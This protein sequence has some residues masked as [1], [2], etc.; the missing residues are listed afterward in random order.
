VAFVLERRWQEEVRGEFERPVP[1]SSAALGTKPP[2]F[3]EAVRLLESVA[4]ED[5][6]NEPA[7]SALSQL[8]IEDGRREDALALWDKAARDAKG[9]AAPLLERYAELLLA[10]RKHK[11]FV[12][13]QMRII[14]DEADVNR[15]RESF[16]RMLER[17]LWADV[18]QTNSLPDDELKKR[19]E[20]VIAALQ[21]RSR[22][23]PFEGFWHEALAAVHDKEGDA[24]KAFAE[25]KQAYYTAP[26]T[27]YSLDQLRAAALKVGDQK[28]AIYFQKQIAASAA[29]KDEAGEWRQLVT[30]LEQDFRMA[31]ADQ[32]R[33]RMEARFSHDPAALDELALY[34]LETGQDDA[35][36][37]VQEQLARVRSWEGKN[38]LRLALQ[39]RRDGDDAAAERVLLQ[40][41]ATSPTAPAAANVPAERLPWPLLDE[42]KAQA[43]SPATLLTA[44]DN[45]PGLEQKERDRLRAFLSLPRS[46]FVDVP[47]DAPQVR[48]RAVEE[49]AKLRTEGNRRKA[50]QA[51][52]KAPA[53]SGSALTAVEQAWMDYYSK[54]GAAFREFL[55]L[56]FANTDSLEARFAFTWLAVKSHG[57]ADVIAWV[58]EAKTTDATRTAR[59]AM[60][61]VVVNML[62][63]DVSFEFAQ[64]DIET[65]G[66]A[67]VYSNTETI[68]IARKLSSRQRHSL[69]LALTAAAQRNDPSLAAE[70]AAHLAPLAN[71]AGRKDL[72][73]RFLRQAWEKPLEAGSP[74]AS[75]T[76]AQTTEKLYRLAA[77]SQERE[78][79]LR[80]SWTRLRQLPPSGQGALMEARLLGLAGA[81]EASAQRLADYM[82]NGFLTARSFIEPIMGRGLPTG[83]PPPGPRIDEVTHMRGYWEDVREWGSI[84]QA[85]G[86]A[87]ELL[88]ADRAVTQRHAGVPMGPKSNYEFTA[89]RNQ[90][91]LRRLRF[92]NPPQ[93][94]R[95]IREYLETDDS[96]ETLIELGS[97]LEGQGRMRDCVEVYRRLPERAFAN[98]EYCEQFL[99]VCENSWECGIPI[100]YID[101]LFG[102]EP[103]FRPLNMAENLLEEKQALFL[104][105]LHDPVRLQLGAFRSGTNAR[106]LPG[107]IP[108][109]VPYLRQLGLLL[110]RTGDKPGALAAWEELCEVYPQD[111]EGAVHRARLLLGQGNKTRAL[112][113]VRNVSMANL[114]IE[115]VR[116]AVRLRV[117]L[118]AEAGNWDE[119]REVMNTICGGTKSAATPHTLTVIIVAAEL[120]SHDRGMEAEG[121]LLRA[122]RA[123]KDA[124]DR[125]R[126]R[127]EQIKLRARDLSWQ[128]KH[129]TARISALVRLEATDPD[130][131]N[132]WVKFLTREA[133]TERASPWIDTLASFPVGQ[134]SALGLSAFGAQLTEQQASLLPSA[135]LK[136]YGEGTAAQRLAA[137]A[138]LDQGKPAWAHAV[139]TSGRGRALRYQPIMVRVLHALGD[140]HGVDEIFARLVRERFPGGGDV[141]DFCSAFADIGHMDF[142]NRLCE[143]A[144]EQQ[145]GTG[146]SHTPLVHRFAR[147]LIEQRRFEEA[148]ILV[149]REDDALT[150]DTAQ[151]LVELYRNWN[152]LDRLPQELAKFHL[153]DGMRSEAEFLAK[154]QTQ[155]KGK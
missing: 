8:Y 56:Q 34:Y 11:D 115:P 108:P 33:R 77:T 111:E 17:L 49:L 7:L 126:L 75:D 28:T 26:D 116:Q 155:T 59:K 79:L 82:S 65:L 76:F 138:L 143:L 127:L 95:I 42:R 13:V 69:A 117:Q 22:R 58:R 145:R 40:V 96:V 125:F 45:A 107:R 139:A 41:L 9:N 150:V 133:Q 87:P 6:Q 1:L 68:D 31:E 27:P 39:Q 121:L 102:A 98:V 118:A 50:Q 5:P 99:R 48:L 141:A 105:R 15:R 36:R 54:N 86:L 63:D 18:V 113:S 137:K 30:L 103:Q 97:F 136:M 104:A 3:H 46:E 144:L 60:L 72:E 123:A 112:E 66:A 146:M 67:M 88:A 43:V 129:D 84:L 62:A 109:K 140:R 23:A 110:E 93:R 71:A 35:A 151:I 85:E 134:V 78:K 92:S 91:L 52:A 147:L 154:L 37:R 120:S 122:E 135:W 38:L 12:E 25:M 44:L 29:P 51:G 80:E 132:D 101:H 70:Y 47:E 130:A 10:Q 94:V 24:A 152:K 57:M 21:E 142:A 153:P 20:V 114:W 89:W 119:V 55:R 106:A 53:D 128:P 4:K 149:M 100:P 2:G 61:Q 73:M 83:M 148:E 32:A 90:A 64:S 81:E 131:L 19:L 74:S 124:N 16:S 14:T